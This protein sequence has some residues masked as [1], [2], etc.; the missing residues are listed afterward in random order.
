MAAIWRLTA[1]ATLE[2][3][4]PGS[5]TSIVLPPDPVWWHSAAGSAE[6]FG[7]PRPEAMS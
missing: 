1:P 6:P 7:V 4:L 3:W 5:V 2:L